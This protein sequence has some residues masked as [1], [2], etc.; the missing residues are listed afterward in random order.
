MTVIVWDDSDIG[1]SIV[2]VTM[3]VT[4]SV[5]VVIDVPAEVVV[6]VMVATMVVAVFAQINVHLL[7]QA[8]AKIDNG[9][10]EAYGGQKRSG[11]VAHLHGRGLTGRRLP[12]QLSHIL[13]L[14]AVHLYGFPPDSNTEIRMRH[15]IVVLVCDLVEIASKSYCGEKSQCTNQMFL[16]YHTNGAFE[17]VK[18]LKLRCTFLPQKP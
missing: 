3:V 7:H 5:A 15:R 16:R 11:G 10:R 12:H 2:V 14:S 13:D 1:D 6:L 18:R 4:R 17:R 8:L 9:K